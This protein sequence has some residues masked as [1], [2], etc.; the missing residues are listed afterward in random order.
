VES[1]SHGNI[2]G[3]SKCSSTKKRKCPV[4]DPSKIAWHRHLSTIDQQSR[5]LPWN[6][7]CVLDGSA[8][9]DATKRYFFWVVALTMSGS[10]FDDAAS[11]RLPI[12]LDPSADE[13]VAA[14]SS[15]LCSYPLLI[16]KAKIPGYHLSKSSKT[17]NY[18]LSQ[19]SH[20]NTIT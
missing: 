20:S 13:A 5:G 2:T 8:V 12:G 17:F 11:S 1:G 6:G 14:L 15:I 7:Y 18:L 16:S 19:L 3:W 10:S 9:S 4:R